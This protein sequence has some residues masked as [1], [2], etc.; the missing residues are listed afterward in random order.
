MKRA[1]KNQS[2][3]TLVEDLGRKHTVKNGGLV[4]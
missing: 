1:R 2:L 4:H 3:R